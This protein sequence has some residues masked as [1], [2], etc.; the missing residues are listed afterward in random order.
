MRVERSFAFLDLSGFTRFT[1][2]HGDE[3]AVRLLTRFRAHVRESAS[4]HAVRVDKWLGD[5]VMLVSTKEE[6]L[7]DAAVGLMRAGVVAEATGG[8]P[9]RGGLATG[10][11]LLLEGDDYVGSAVNL[12]S[13]LCTAAG[14]GELLATAST[15]DALPEGTTAIARGALHVPGF[16]TPIEVI[17][18]GDD[19]ALALPRDETAIIFPKAG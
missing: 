5:G 15:A 4:D 11:V 16:T 17:C 12:A 6:R 9:L 14:P 2:L 7:V 10:P 13:R 3:E 19:S 8:L 18:V 1:D